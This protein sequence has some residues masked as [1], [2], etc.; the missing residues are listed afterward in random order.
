M[1]FTK[2]HKERAQVLEKVA[3]SGLARYF[4]EQTELYMNRAQNIE[5]AEDM[6]KSFEDM[7]QTQ[8][9]LKL[10]EDIGKG[11]YRL[12]F[13]ALVAETERAIEEEEKENKEGDSN[14]NG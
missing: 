1:P 8:K 4:A 11:K 9:N 12:L 2:E 14:E 10:L 3:A 6:L 7:Q 5:T 13:M